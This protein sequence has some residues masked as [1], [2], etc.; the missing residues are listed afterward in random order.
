MYRGLLACTYLER[1]LINKNIRLKGIDAALSK[2][3]IFNLFNNQGALH[4]A[5]I[6]P[7]TFTMI[8]MVF[9]IHQHWTPHKRICCCCTIELVT[10]PSEFKSFC[11]GV[12]SEKNNFVTNGWKVPAEFQQVLTRQSSYRSIQKPVHYIRVGIV[13]RGVVR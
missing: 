12:R 5:N 2:P 3:Q 10:S 4:V 11:H 1:V 13:Q 6:S 8:F 7:P 9:L